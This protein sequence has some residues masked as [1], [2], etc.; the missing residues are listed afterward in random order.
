MHLHGDPAVRFMV[1]LVFVGHRI[2]GAGVAY[3]RQP[4]DENK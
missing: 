2:L 3:G 1:V 4:K